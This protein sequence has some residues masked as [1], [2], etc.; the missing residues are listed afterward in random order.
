MLE[1]ARSTPASNPNGRSLIGLGV[2]SLNQ[3]E[4]KLYISIKVIISA[5]IP[6]SIA[7][8]EHMREF[9]GMVDRNVVHSNTIRGVLAEMR[10]LVEGK[11][12]KEIVRFTE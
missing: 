3:R 9:G 2:L 4:E 11:I 5:N 6:T 8:S 7:N 12:T 1:S 10:L